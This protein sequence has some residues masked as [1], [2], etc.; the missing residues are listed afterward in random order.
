MNDTPPQP[1]AQISDS[2]QFVAW[3]RQVAPYVH[4]HR[5]RTF[6]IAFSGSLIEAG[7]LTALI[8]DV[9]LLSAIPTTVSL[10]GL[11]LRPVTSMY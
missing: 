1:V 5:G 7:A 6:V 9:S 4:A 3:L 8:Q 10:S 11:T 2:T